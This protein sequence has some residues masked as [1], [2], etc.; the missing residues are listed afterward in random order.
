MVQVLIYVSSFENTGVVVES[1]FKVVSPHIY[2]YIHIWRRLIY[3][4]IQE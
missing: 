1:L 2:I 4:G 3:G